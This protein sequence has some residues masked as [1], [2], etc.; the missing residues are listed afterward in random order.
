MK[1]FFSLVSAALV[2]P[3]SVALHAVNR[4]QNLMGCTAAVVGSGMIG[5]LAI[6]ALRMAGCKQVIAIDIEDSR[7]K[8]ASELGATASINSSQSNSIAD[9]LKLTNGKGADVAMEVV[10]SGTWT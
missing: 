9:V 2:E 10:G 6:Q 5:L 4:L 3:V 7:L 1:P 8:I